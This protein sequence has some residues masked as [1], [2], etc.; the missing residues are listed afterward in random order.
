MNGLTIG[1]WEI[2]D[3]SLQWIGR[4]AV[5]LLFRWHFAGDEGAL[6]AATGGSC[7]CVLFGGVLGFAL[8]NSSQNVSAIDATILGGSLGVCMG[9]CFGASVETASST[10][11]EMLKSLDSK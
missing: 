1:V 6:S 2:A 9:F 8:S 10:I 4:G 5:W 11:K 3:R 7:V